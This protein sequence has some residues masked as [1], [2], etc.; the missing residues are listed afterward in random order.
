M[1]P[2]RAARAGVEDGQ[3]AL[4]AEEGH[5]RVA[6]DDERRGLGG[7]QAVAGERAPEVAEVVATLEKLHGLVGKGILSQAEFDANV[8]KFGETVAKQ[9]HIPDAQKNLVEQANFGNYD[10]DRSG[11]SEMDALVAYLR[12]HLSRAGGDQ[13][14]S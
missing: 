5:V 12:G 7:G 1:E 3:P 14:V 9:L 13:R 4:L 11:I 8:A 6:A 10:G 2:P